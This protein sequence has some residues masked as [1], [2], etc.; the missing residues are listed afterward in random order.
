M[1]LNRIFPFLDAQLELRE[2]SL[3]LFLFVLWL[4]ALVLIVGAPWWFT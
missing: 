3:E 2:R 1:N 4:T